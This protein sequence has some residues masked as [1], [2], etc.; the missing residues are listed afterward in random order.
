MVEPVTV[1]ESVW[2]AMER[3]TTVSGFRGSVAV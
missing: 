2:G 1:T 3:V